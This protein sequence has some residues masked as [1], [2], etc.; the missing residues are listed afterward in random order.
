M[1][2]IGYQVDAN[3]PMNNVQ[4]L[5][6]SGT[7]EKLREDNNHSAA[8]ITSQNYSRTYLENFQ[9]MAKNICGTEARHGK[10]GSIEHQRGEEE[11]ENYSVANDGVTSELLPGIL[12]EYEEQNSLAVN[13]NWAN[14]T[15]QLD[16]PSSEQPE[17][18]KNFT[19][20]V[21]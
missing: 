13:S 12:V 4:V 5:L 18:I 11:V 14:Y 20:E 7:C 8:N 10:E 15:K 2:E 1:E 16:H 9:C 19:C 21:N 3:L 17:L 6:V